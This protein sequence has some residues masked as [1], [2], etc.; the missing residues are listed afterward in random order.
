MKY[1]KIYFDLVRSR[2]PV[3]GQLGV[4]C[5]DQGTEFVNTAVK[6][7]LFTYGMTHQTSEP[8]VS[9]HND[10]IERFHRTLEERTRALLLESGFPA[11][12]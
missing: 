2:F 6:H 11:A 10:L 9:Q 1:L 8:F 7:L 4:L 5:T 3:P 12:L